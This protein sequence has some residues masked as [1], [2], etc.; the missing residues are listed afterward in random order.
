MICCD[1]GIPYA[2]IYYVCSKNV[3]DVASLVV[4]GIEPL[5]TTMQYENHMPAIWK[6]IISG[7]LVG[8]KQFLPATSIPPNILF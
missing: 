6:I 3:P 4:C 7:K 8:K 2:K 1:H 5:W